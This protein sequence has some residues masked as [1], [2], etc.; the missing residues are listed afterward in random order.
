MT[1]PVTCMSLDFPLYRFRTMWTISYCTKSS[2]A[3]ICKCCKYSSFEFVC[4]LQP[5]IGIQREARKWTHT[6][7]MRRHSLLL[8]KI[9][10]THAMGEEGFDKLINLP[11][12][13]LPLISCP[14]SQTASLLKVGSNPAQ[15]PSRNSDTL[16]LYFKDMGEEMERCTFLGQN[17]IITE[18]GR[19]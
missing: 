19:L 14:H 11:Q 7:P 2:S 9:Y 15:R 5:K 8:K 1:N 10:C 13:L 16:S 3:P 17:C 18:N 6:Q 4:T 12:V